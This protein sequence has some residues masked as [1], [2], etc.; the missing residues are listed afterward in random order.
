[1]ARNNQECTGGSDCGEG[2]SGTQ[3]AIPARAQRKTGGV[4]RQ[5]QRP[6]LWGQPATNAGGTHES[7]VA[8]FS[9]LRG[10]EDEERSATQ[11][12]AF[13]AFHAAAPTVRSERRGCRA[14]AAARR[15]H[16]RAS[17]RSVPQYLLT[18]T[19]FFPLVSPCVT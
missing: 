3:R 7:T 4:E 6:Q 11:G 17:M 14:D 2:E 1:M 12:A 19:L 8:S 13:P 18:R 5:Q 15:A 10:S 9:G 16:A